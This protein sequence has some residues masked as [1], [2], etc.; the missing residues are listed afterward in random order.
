M[1]ENTDKILEAVEVA[2][3]TGK[4]KKGANETTKAVERGNAEL[5]IV[6]ED[7]SPE[8]IVMHIPI[9]SE[10]KDT[11]CV[12]VPKQDDLGASAGLEVGSSAVA[13]TEAGEA[14][15]LIEEIT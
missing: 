12:E 13:I 8:E 10:E 6:A 2:N 14:E 11:P 9:I 1:S 15:E 3:V 4:I 7:V 5:A